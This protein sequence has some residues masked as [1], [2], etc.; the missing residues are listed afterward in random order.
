MTLLPGEFAGTT[1]FEVLRRLG[2]GGFGVVFSV[3]DR[4]RDERV[5]LKTLRWADPA[6]IYRLKKEFRSL[7]DVVHP[8]LVGLYELIAHDEQWFFTMEHVSGVE[9]TE[10]VRTPELSVERLRSALRQTVEGVAAIHAAGK[11]HRDLKPSNVLV[12]PEGRAVILDFGVVGEMASGD[13]ALE[14]ADEG[15]MGTAA[16]MAPEQV[17]GQAG[18]PADWYAL[19]TMLYEALTGRLPYAGTAFVILSN[20]HTVDPV[21]PQVIAPGVPADLAELCLRLLARNA[22]DRPGYAE[23]LRALGEQ[24]P[25][26]DRRPRSLDADLALVGREFQLAAL[27]EAFAASGEGEAV[28]IYVQGPSGIGK[29][30]LVQRFVDDLAR[31]ARALPLTGR[32]FVR[33]T[34]PY[35]GFDGVIDALSRYLRAL[36]PEDLDRLLPADVAA[37]TRLF[38]VLARVEGIEALLNTAQ[39]AHD[40]VD[41]RLRAFGALRA[42]LGR[43][44]SSRPVVIWIDDFQWADVDTLLL[45]NDLMSEPDPP[46]LL[47]V[48]SFRSEERDTHPLLRALLERAKT[49]RVRQVTI[50]PFSEP[51]ARHLAR[52]LLG[53]GEP[54]ADARADARAAAIARE[55]GGS[56]FLVEQLVAHSLAS[57][58]DAPTAGVSLAEMLEARLARLPE[59]ASGLLEVVATAGRPIG[60]KIAL[61]AAGTSGEVRPLLMRLGAEHLLRATSTVD[62][63]EL[64]HDRLRET[65]TAQLDRE[66]LGGLHLRLAQAMEAHGAD[67]PEALYEHFA[68]AGRRQSAAEYARRSAQRAES[69]LA[70]E[71]AALFYQRAIELADGEADARDLTALRIGLADALANAGRGP[72]AADVYL[73][74]AGAS[75][76]AE[77]LRLRRRAAEELIRSGHGDRGLAV[78]ET[79]LRAR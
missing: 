69:A 26:S 27:T 1:R 76:E 40:P 30:T 31:T 37:L 36:S 68:A 51:A 78:L 14:T 60:S 8:N 42:M 52:V 56:P 13:A 71:R 73:T 41:L 22:A 57:G 59:G 45:L 44:R 46:S 2:S 24:A 7:A 21:A 34:V 11:L 15:A 10:F 64:Y 72:E 17:S 55:A 74:A 62:Q 50:Q 48:A 79:G 39:P 58:E 20:K 38:P 4:E 77:A 3:H 16:Y 49:G 12:T 67:D 32:C 25:T 65:L 5:A 61:E 75:D 66:R 33:E 43:I 29:S 63:I 19:G 28:S 47:V 53:D 70:F 18:A 9:F 35:K 54:E 6:A 23:I